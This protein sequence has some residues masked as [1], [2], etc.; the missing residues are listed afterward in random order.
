MSSWDKEGFR[1]GFNSTNQPD[2]LLWS[3]PGRITFVYG[4][5]KLLCGRRN[6][7][8]W[9]WETVTLP[10]VVAQGQHCADA[11]GRIWY[12]RGEHEIGVWNGKEMEIVSLTPR[13]GARP[14]SVGSGKI[15]QDLPPDRSGRAQPE[16]QLAPTNVGGDADMARGLKGRTIKV[17]TADAKGLIWIGTDQA[18]AEW[19]TDHFEVMTPTNGEAVLE[20][21]RIVPSGTG[22]L[23]VQANA[24]MR[25]CANRQWLA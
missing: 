25:R 5:G 4:D 17:L 24:R 12:L 23:W 18:L 3:A 10:G 6:G 19:K 11:E 9:D 13:G 16:D 8:Q 21:K 2:R 22:D 1:P 20:I 14:A 15:Q 7:K